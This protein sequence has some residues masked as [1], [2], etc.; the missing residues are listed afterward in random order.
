VSAALTTP[1]AP[2]GQV[3]LMPHGPFSLAA[4][5]SFLESFGPAAYPGAGAGHLHLAF[6]ADGGEEPAGVCV[7]RAGQAVEASVFGA[8]RPEVV[9]A[10]LARILSLDVDGRAF[11]AVGVR[12]P[13]IG[14]LQVRYPGLRPVAFFS[15]YEAGAWAILSQR[16]RIAQAARLKAHITEVHGPAVT[17]HDETWRAFPGPRR[18]LALPEIAGVSAPKMERLRALATATLEGTL[19]AARLRGMPTDEALATLQQ[20]PGIGPFSAGLIL[21]RGAGALDG[22]PLSEPRLARAVALAYD[23]PA[24][25]DAETI[26]SMAESWRPYRTWACL[27]LRVHLEAETAGDRALC[28]ATRDVAGSGLKDTWWSG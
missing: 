13:V 17:I 7:Q 6:V 28:P 15:P 18:L 9:W 10:Q 8:V 5:T 3:T 26:I 14:R 20:L 25:P 23:L 21:L 12:D 27:L 19:D 1:N 24:P 16:L 2:R 22:L 11:P 4:S